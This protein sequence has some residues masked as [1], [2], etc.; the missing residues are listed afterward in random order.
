MK[1][2]INLIISPL[3][4]KL[5]IPS[6]HE[7]VLLGEW[8]EIFNTKNDHLEN[9]KSIPYHWD[10]R[11]KLIKDYYYLDS[12]Y[13]EFLDLLKYKMNKIHNVN[14]SK[15]YWRI[16]IGPWL[17]HFIHI[18]FDRWSMLKIAQENFEVSEVYAESR[19]S[20]I[21]PND[22]SSFMKLMTTE[23]WNT[24]IYIELIKNFTKMKLNK[25]TKNQILL[26]K[27]KKGKKNNFIK[28]LFNL[29]NYFS[30]SDNIFFINTY[31]KTYE[32]LKLQ[33]KL[34]Q[35]PKY[36]EDE[37]LILESQYNEK[38]RKWNFSNNEEN[39]FKKILRYM[40]PKFMPISYLESYSEIQSS[41]KETNWPSNPKIIF[42]ANSHIH[43]DKFKLWCA[44]KTER[45]AKLVIGQHGGGLTTKLFSSHFDHEL[46][47][48]DKYLVW[49]NETL[50][51]DKVV[52]FYNFK[53][54]RK[55]KIFN[56][57]N[58]N[59]NL[60]IVLNTVPKYSHSIRGSMI[61]T[62]YL[63]YLK[64][65]SEVIKSIIIDKN[66]N[67]KIRLNKIDY[68][69]FTSER[70]EGLSSHIQ[71]DTGKKDIIENLKESSLCISTTN[72]TTYL[73]SI[74]LNIPT[75]IYFDKK[76]DQINVKV[77]EQFEELRKVGLFYDD[78]YALSQKINE[79]S[80][81]IQ[82]WWKSNLIQQEVFKF[83]QSF[84]RESKN[85]TKDLSKFFSDELNKK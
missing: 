55:K 70:V 42:T 18:I 45:N 44:E 52:P 49:G 9:I 82:S 30:K 40:I 2:K 38:I 11:E 16:V 76:F 3:E 75:L 13:E 26:S 79:I 71:I 41:L 10:N 85:I 32:L 19:S 83:K 60:M 8:C 63:S 67:Y 50:N 74:Y 6:S 31:L 4:S 5:N 72:S 80:P 58:Y 54:Q 27:N 37:E 53:M 84:S 56:Q 65:I 46:K 7:F 24:E 36:F 68:D 28:N 69:W 29:I 59:K 57:N 25:K 51:L 47:I 1:K 33:I 62:Q 22:C 66:I 21:T 61:S 12:V 73:E 15:K 48:S 14:F 78:P 23:S 64:N 17:L 20:N 81:D 43:N 34:K 39:K 35:I 77:K